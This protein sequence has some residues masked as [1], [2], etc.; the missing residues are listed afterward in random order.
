MSAAR[1]RPLPAFAKEKYGSKG[2]KLSQEVTSSLR[3]Y[4]KRGIDKR[5]FG[6]GESTLA[7]KLLMVEIQ[8]GGG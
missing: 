3:R 2:R 6:G 5:F 8:R 7:G 1:K 4:W